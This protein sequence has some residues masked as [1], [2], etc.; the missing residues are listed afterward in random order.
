MNWDNGDREDHHLRGE[1]A[2]ESPV[3]TCIEY[4]PNALMFL[5]IGLLLLYNPYIVL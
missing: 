1:Q 2:K 4:V 5:N 3:N